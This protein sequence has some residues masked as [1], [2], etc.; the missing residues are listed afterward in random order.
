MNMFIITE[1]E[2][3]EQWVNKYTYMFMVVKVTEV[4]NSL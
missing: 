2:T 1:A 3:W 4:V